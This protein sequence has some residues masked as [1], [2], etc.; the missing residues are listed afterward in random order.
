MSSAQKGD[1]LPLLFFLGVL[2]LP[3]IAAFLPF[4]ANG[5]GGLGEEETAVEKGEMVDGAVDEGYLD[6]S[7]MKAAVDE[8]GEMLREKIKDDAEVECKAKRQEH[9]ETWGNKNEGKLQEDKEVEMDKE[10]EVVEEKEE[11]DWVS[12]TV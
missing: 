10:E 11:D 7:K 5:N 1:L 6:G 8:R 9:G 3:I 12:I 2:S 4:T